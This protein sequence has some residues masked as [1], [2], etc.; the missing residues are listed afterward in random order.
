MIDDIKFSIVVVAYKKHF[1]LKC[2]LYSL[3]CQTYN[4][5][6]IIVIHD[7]VDAEHNL[8]MQEFLKDDRIKYIQTNQRYNDWGMTLRNIGLGIVSGDF[9]INTND[10]NYYTPNCLEELHSELV[11]NKECNFIYFDSVDKNFQWQNEKQQPYSLFKPL[12]KVNHI[13]MGQ[14]AV[15]KELIGDIKFKIHYSGDGLF[16]NDLLP[17][18]N[19]VYVEKVLFI[20]N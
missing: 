20:H 14:F 15:K 10:D 18:I 6:E 13:D 9:I 2:L 4:N 11:K 1:E 5:F 8:T 3:L 17:K 7:G 16:V 12:L 19:P